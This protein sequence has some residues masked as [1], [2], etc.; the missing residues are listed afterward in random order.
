MPART[1]VLDRLGLARALSCPPTGIF[2]P[3]IS[4][5][6]TASVRECCII[7]KATAEPRK[8]SSTSRRAGCPF[9]TTRKAVPKAVFG[10]LLLQALCP[11]PELMRLPFTASQTA[12]AECFVSLLLRPVVCPATEGFV[13]ERSM[14]VRCFAPG[15]LVSK[16]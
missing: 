5:R 13:A 7:R 10:R 9:P 12:Q 14:E 1:F 4:S 2:T 6:P 3:P 16:S 15:G 8:A 11:P